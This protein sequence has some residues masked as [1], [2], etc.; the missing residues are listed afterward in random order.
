M[1]ALQPD[2]SSFRRTP[3]KSLG[4]MSFSREAPGCS[5]GECHCDPF[6]LKSLLG[7]TTLAMPNQYVAAV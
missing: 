6:A 5:H 2:A 3:G 1:L 4:I 7:H